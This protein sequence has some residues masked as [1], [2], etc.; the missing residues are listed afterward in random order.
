MRLIDAGHT[1]YFAGGCVRDTL[2]GI[3]PKDYDIATSA[4]PDEVQALFSKSNAIGAHFGVILVNTQGFPFEIATFRHDGSYIDG[5]HPESVTFSNPEDDASRR[6]FTVNGLFQNPANGE[7]IDFVNGQHDLE[8]KLLR[9]IGE[10]ADRFK[11]DAL[12]L[13]RAIRFAAT[14]GFQIEPAT[15]SAIGANAGLLAKISAERIRDEFT[16]IL[17]SPYRAHGLDLLVQSGLM[18]HVVPEVNDLIG[19]EQPPQW[20]PE[21]DVYIHTRIMLE[22]L[23]DDPSPELALAVLLHDIGKPATF[24]YDEA[25][26]RI[27]FNNHDRIGAEMAETILS[28]LKYSKHITRNVCNMVANH[29]NFM[30]VQN[31]RTAKVKRFMARPTYEDEMELHRVD[32]ASSNGFTDNYEFL[33]AKEKEFASQPLIPP[34]LLTGDDLIGLGMEPGPRFAEILG[35]V[36]T[37]QLEG[38]LSSR[39]EALD[40]LNSEEF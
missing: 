37:E 12:R 3:E 21:G 18:R 15:W 26:Q 24:S 17:T 10:P 11:E 2:L 38:R 13:M 29:M 7:V 16:M 28:R 23:G 40:F 31:M 6:D 33:R 27:R 30:N 19:C 39:Q 8:A 5:R 35:R 9:A 25:E 14:L 4:T 1:A 22:M 36:Q 32:C 34:P 20:H